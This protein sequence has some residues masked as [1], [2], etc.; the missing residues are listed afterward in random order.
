MLFRGTQITESAIFPIFAGAV[1]DPRAVETLTRSP[2]ATPKE[3]ARV[4]EMRT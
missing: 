2:S 4:D 1:I 3:F